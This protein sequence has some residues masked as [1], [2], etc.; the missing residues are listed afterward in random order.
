MP[1]PFLEKVKGQNLNGSEGRINRSASTDKTAA[2][3]RQSDDRHARCRSTSRRNCQAKAGKCG[4]SVRIR[5]S[6]AAFRSPISGDRRPGK[7]WKP[8][9]YYYGALEMDRH[10]RGKDSEQRWRHVKMWSR[11]DRHQPSFNDIR[12]RVELFSRCQPVATAACRSPIEGGR[13]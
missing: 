11:E 8:R 13:K 1:A 4:P 7:M 10:W 2:R 6:Q 9:D 5:S 12:Q 3:D